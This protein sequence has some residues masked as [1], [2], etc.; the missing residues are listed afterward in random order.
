M[1]E[2]PIVEEVHKA[3]ERILEKYPTR[4]ELATQ[5]QEIEREFSERVVRLEPKAPVTNER[6][7]S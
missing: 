4:E 5:W 1:I 3:R 7:I 6:K 2:D